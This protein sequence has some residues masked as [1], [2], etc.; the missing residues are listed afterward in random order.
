MVYHDCHKR[1]NGVNNVYLFTRTPYLGVFK[2]TFYLEGVVHFG[3]GGVAAAKRSLLC[4]TGG[5]SPTM[6]CR[7]G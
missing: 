2:I 7:S 3:L 1:Y 6:V 5:L 4:T